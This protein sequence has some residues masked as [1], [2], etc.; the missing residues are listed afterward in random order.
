M[1]T[2]VYPS[3]IRVH[4]CDEKKR[5]AVLARIISWPLH[6]VTTRCTKGSPRERMP[7]VFALLHAERQ[8]ITLSWHAAN[9]TVTPSTFTHKHEEM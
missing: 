7:L 6:A 2:H 5:E 3:R 8:V 1:Q 4:P 9:G